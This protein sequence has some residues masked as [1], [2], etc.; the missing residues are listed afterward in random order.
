MAC[1]RLELDLAALV[2]QHA[3]RKIRIAHLLRLVDDVVHIL[4]KDNCIN[5]FAYDILG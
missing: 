4:D 2:P 1:N 5:G 3:S